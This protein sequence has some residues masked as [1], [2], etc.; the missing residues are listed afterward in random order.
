[1]NRFLLDPTSAAGGKYSHS[2]I[3]ASTIA[4][5]ASNPVVLRKALE[6]CSQL[7]SDGYTEYVTE[8]YRRGLTVAGDDWVFMDIISVLFAAA[9]LGQP[10]NYLEIGVRRGRSVCA[11]IA[12]SPATN[13]YAF[14]IWQQGYAGNDNVG[15]PLVTRELRRFG[16]TGRVQFVDG[17][18]HQTV[19]EFMADNPGLTFDLITVDGDHSIDGAMDDLRNVMP[20]LRAG[21][22]L[23][24]DDT[25]NPYC[26][27]LMDVW[28]QFLKSEPSLVGFS[29]NEIGTGI[30]FGVRRRAGSDPDLSLETAEATG[31][32][33]LVA[34]RRR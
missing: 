7:E 33:A 29:F 34:K 20:R 32:W 13:V 16:H 21:G 4:R 23:V 19:P 25:G 1:M 14:D 12:A 15:P 5:R 8:F 22:V 31:L 6:L 28:Q 2:F 10:E 27:G 3:S 17:D 9:E 30:S 24:F 11:V 26:A 18:S